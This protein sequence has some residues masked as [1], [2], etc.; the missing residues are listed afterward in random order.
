MGFGSGRR[1]G[2]SPDDDGRPCV[3]SRWGSDSE[4]AVVRP[5]LG[6]FSPTGRL[7]GSRLLGGGPAFRTEINVPSL[8]DL[9]LK[10]RLLE[11]LL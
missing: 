8:P 1:R 4:G 2:Q 5:V 9:S 7:V 6:V 10:E 11:G 3:G